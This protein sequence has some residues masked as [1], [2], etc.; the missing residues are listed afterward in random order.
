QSGGAETTMAKQ[1]TAALV[2]LL[3]WSQMA[4]GQMP[5]MQPWQ[6]P[7]PKAAGPQAPDGAFAPPGANVRAPEFCPQNSLPA[8]SAV[9]SPFGQPP[10]PGNAFDDCGPPEAHPYCFWSIGAMALTRQGLGNGTI[11]VRDPNNMDTGIIPASA[12]QE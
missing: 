10:E 9:L 8:G 1:W 6:A 4:L 2:A 12:P 3:G 11:A 7:Q 5:P